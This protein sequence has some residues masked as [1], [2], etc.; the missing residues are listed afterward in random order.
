MDMSVSLK[1]FKEKIRNKLLEIHWKQWSA[2][3]VAS[4]VPAENYWIIDL[5]A[6]IIS[7]LVI[8]LLDKRL[9]S[10]CIEWL[11]KNGEWVNFARLKRI[12]KAFMI[13]LPN[14]K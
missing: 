13:P 14:M 4:H 2:L 11:I 9:L 10:V 6:L 1:E 7:T 5:E 8:G 12:C 3:N